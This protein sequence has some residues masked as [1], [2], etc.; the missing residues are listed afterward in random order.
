DGAPLRLVSVRGQLAD[1]RAALAYVRA[2]D[3]V[4]PAWIA[5]W[6]TSF[7]GGHVMKIAAGDPAIAACV[8]QVPYTAGVAL[9]RTHGFGGSAR[10]LLAAR[11]DAVRALFGRA[12]HRIPVVGA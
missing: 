7:S 4:D 10:I 11:R 9:L 6:G 12:P 5:L 8:A 1:W 2:R 3:D